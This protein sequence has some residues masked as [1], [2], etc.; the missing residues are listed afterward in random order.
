M[1]CGRNPSGFL[2]YTHEARMTAI[3][4]YSGRN[5][6]SGADRIASPPDERATAFATFFAYGGR[7]TMTGNKITHHVE[8]ASVENWV[9][10]DLVRT[11]KLEGD[12]MTLITPPLSVGGRMQTTELVWER[13][14]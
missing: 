13:L 14:H 2:I 10:T 4:S 7:Y 12:R 11:I 1:A 5:R 3:I 6:L 8:V 9:K